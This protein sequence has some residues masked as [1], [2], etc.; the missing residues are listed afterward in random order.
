MR[1]LTSVHSYHFV[2]KDNPREEVLPINPPS[3]TP[4]AFDKNMYLEILREDPPLRRFVSRGDTPDDIDI[5]G[6]HQDADRAIWRV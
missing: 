2:V 4:P 5:P 3:D 1:L 6:P